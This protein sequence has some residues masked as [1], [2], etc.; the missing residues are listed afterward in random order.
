M[1]DLK[2]HDK[3]E[4]FTW[5]MPKGPFSFFSDEDIR[6]FDEN[7]YIIL[8]DAFDAQEISSV[9]EQIDPFEYNVTEALRGLDGRNNFYNTPSYTIRSIKNI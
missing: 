3:N 8:E 5:S 6:C 9:I 7:G 1:Q 4:G 2:L